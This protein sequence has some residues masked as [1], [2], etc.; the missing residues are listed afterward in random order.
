MAIYG[1]FYGLIE[2]NIRRS[3]AF[4]VINQL[5]FKILAVGLGSPLAIAGAC[6]HAVC[7]VIY[8][9]V[10]WM[11][12]GSIIERTGKENFS[13]LSK[14]LRKHMP[15]IFSY[16]LIGV[17][18]ISSFP[19]TSGFVS[20]K[21]IIK[22]LEKASLFTPW[23]ILEFA[24]FGVILFIACKFVYFAFFNHT[25]SLDF[26]VKKINPF[27]AISTSIMAFLCIFIGLFP[28]FLYKHVPYSSTLLK[29]APSYF[30]AIY[31]KYF[32]NVVIAIQKFLFAVLAFILLRKSHF[33]KSKISVD[34]DWLYRRLLRYIT[35]FIIAF[36]DFIYGF[37]NSLTMSFIKSLSYVF[38]NSL[39]LLLYLINVPVLR[40]SNIPI[41]KNLLMNQY[42]LK[43]VNNAFP[44]F[45][46]G[47]FIFIFAITLTLLS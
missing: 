39:A 43:I 32:P 45:A 25:P 12:A 37:I 41:N 20:K 42:R 22:A 8:N 11:S 18:S 29:Y 13:E 28:E 38:S 34:F 27:M 26:K 35:L 16:V 36:I 46:L 24:S 9:S 47:A 3:L 15:V 14:Y 10:L 17:A 44:F 30:S 2:N 23:L 33:I 1:V 4:S 31:I 6:L 19:F 7:G 21:V 5:G 40:L